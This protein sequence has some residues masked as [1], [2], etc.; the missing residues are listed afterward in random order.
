MYTIGEFSKIN[1]ITTKT[2]RHYDKIGLLKPCRIDG[3]RGYR[4]YSPDQL[5]DIRKILMLKDMGFSLDEIKRIS[6]ESPDTELLIKERVRQLKAE[7]NESQ[8][9]LTRVVDYLSSFDGGVKMNQEVIIKSLPEVI[10][11]SMRTIVPNYDTYFT[12]IPKMGEY[13]ESVGAVCS[14][15]DYCFNI[16][17]DGEY[18]ESDID[19]EI[20]EA[21]VDYC[22][23]SDKVKFKKIDGVPKAACVMHKGPYSR[24]KESYNEVYSWIEKN[25]Y[26]VSDNPR[27]SYIDGIWN[28]DDPEDWL[29]E[30]Q[31][32]LK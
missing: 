3:W 18:K 25:G 5:K 12:I 20:C 4:Y 24:L 28:K 13:M 29:T 23:E 31:V 27:E 22:E 21:V 9:R 16:Y 30:I 8:D 19:V 17:H 6:E 10:V 2:L 32:P 11:A 14:K 7:V 26:K 15:P 1:W